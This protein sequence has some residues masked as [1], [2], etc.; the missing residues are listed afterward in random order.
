MYDINPELSH[1]VPATRT[2]FNRVTRTN[3]KTLADY[4]QIVD[5]AKNYRPSS[6]WIK[7]REHEE[8]ERNKPKPALAELWLGRL[9]G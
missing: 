5:N 3:K 2:G 4:R 9:F 1:L 8:M 6:R 7:Q